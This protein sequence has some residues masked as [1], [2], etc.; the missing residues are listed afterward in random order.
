MR[1]KSDHISLTIE[2]DV[3]FTKWHLRDHILVLKLQILT[4]RKG[5]ENRRAPLLQKSRKV[6]LSELDQ[7][8][9]HLI[10]H[11]LISLE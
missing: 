10:W 11:L 9:H 5:M 4:L 8:P 6:N 1:Q 2:K 3:R 7:E